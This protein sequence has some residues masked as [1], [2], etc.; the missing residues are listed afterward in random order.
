LALGRTAFDIMYAGGGFHDK[1]YVKEK[2]GAPLIFQPID[3]LN[4]TDNYL[5]KSTMQL[6]AA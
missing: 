3:K 2:L 6:L 4:D 5:I 1:E